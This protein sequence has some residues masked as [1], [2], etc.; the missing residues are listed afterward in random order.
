MRAIGADVLLTSHYPVMEGAEA[1]GFLERSLD[2]VRDLRAAV[3]DGL[4]GGETDLWALTRA[5]DRRLG[6]YPEFMTELG[7]S[8]RAHLAVPGTGAAA[9]G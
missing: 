7:A 2:F 3:S 6:P 9:P 8:V 4:R 5:A 1:A